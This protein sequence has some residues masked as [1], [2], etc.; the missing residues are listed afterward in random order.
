[1]SAQFPLDRLRVVYSKA[2]TLP[3]ACLVR[4]RSLIDHTLYWTS[5]SSED[6]AAYLAAILNSETVRS[7]VAALQ[8]RGQF[9]ARHFDKAM[10]NLPIPR[11]DATAVLHTDL[12]AAAREAEVVACAVILPENVKFQRARS[13]IRNAL[14]E[15]SVAQR[16]E[17][18]V[19]RVLD[20]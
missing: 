3:A 11:F 8:A 2:G 4:D 1:L 14:T 7:R 17:A 19:T 9:G 12:A 20:G 6:E 13:L 16:I 10:F 5:A 15:V 18:L